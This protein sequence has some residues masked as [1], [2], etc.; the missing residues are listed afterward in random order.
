MN[1]YD[2]VAQP[3]T[4]ESFDA[5]IKAI[6]TASQKYTFEPVPYIVP[7]ACASFMR[8]AGKGAAKTRDKAFFKA[9]KI[10]GKK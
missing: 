7:L 5:A 1:Y 4:K 3:L 10:K 6:K 8:N 2:N 9:H